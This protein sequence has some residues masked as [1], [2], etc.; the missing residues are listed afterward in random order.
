MGHR[1]GCAY[2]RYYLKHFKNCVGSIHIDPIYKITENI[3]SEAALIEKYAA[4]VI[5][6]SLIE[7][8]LKKYN[9]PSKNDRITIQ[10]K[11][12]M[13]KDRYAKEKAMFK[14]NLTEAGEKTTGKSLRILLH[15]KGKAAEKLP[16]DCDKTVEIEGNEYAWNMDSKD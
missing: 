3:D 1:I 16:A 9:N 12:L 5:T 6:D 10:I 2:L 4:G 15:E 14:T 8:Q 7:A 13:F 11:K